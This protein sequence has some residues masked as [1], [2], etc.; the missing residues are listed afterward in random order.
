[1]SCKTED[2]SQIIYPND[3]PDGEAIKSMNSNIG[4][5]VVFL[6]VSDEFDE[7]YGEEERQKLINFYKERISLHEKSKFLDENHTIENRFKDSGFDLVVP[8]VKDSALVQDGIYFYNPGQKKLC[9]LRVKVGIYKVDDDWGELGPTKYPSP[10]YL[11]ARSS[12]YKTPF[13]LANNVGI[14]DS[15]YR[16]NICAALYNTHST[17]E[18]VE[19]GKRIA[20]ICMPD[21]SFNFHVKLVEELDDTSRGSGGFGSTGH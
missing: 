20:Q 12:I 14:I 13:I 7:N 16:G 3:A 6:K 11:Y 18:V 5:Y 4:D 2:P 1:M 21:L 8:C 17:P 15:G 19:M 10:F 9:N